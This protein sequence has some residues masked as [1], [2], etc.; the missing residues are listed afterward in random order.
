MRVLIYGVNSE[1][2]GAEL[3]LRAASERLLAAGHEPAVSSR[4][5][6][7]R[8]RREIHA[9]GVFSVES[10][11]H[12]R[13]VGLDRLPRTLTDHLSVV[14][15]GQFDYVLDASGYSLTD[16]WGMAP[17][18]TRLNRLRR[19]HAK[20]IGFSMLPQ[21]FGPFTKP[22][23]AGG[24]AKVVAYADV[25]FARDDQSASHLRSAGLDMA[26]ISV[27]PDITI[28]MS[29]APSALT[30]GRTLLVPNWNIAKR[31]DSEGESQYIASLVKTVDGLRSDG[32]D[33]VGLCHEGAKDLAVLQ[34]VDGLVSGGLEILAPRNA[35]EAKSLVA[36]AELV[37][38]GRYH[39]LVS[40]LA[41]GVPAI[42]HS[43]AHKYAALF[44]DFG[45]AEGR[46]ADPMSAEST[47][48][49]VR[50]L[51]MDKER[52]KLTSAKPAINSRLEAMW[53]SIFDVIAT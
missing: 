51:D 3:L 46:L 20:G 30:T 18:T 40:A 14:G 48:A 44:A 26:G 45:L 39:A 9:K 21:A 13:S 33:V 36:G 27:C 22:G 38:A 52:A 8:T 2:K 19:W 32:R 42:A 41:S 43:W 16:A 12:F 5:V 10:A 25:V 28:S 53:Q 7:A 47:L 37:V 1:N 34:E 11:K 29:V 15:D 17:V 4:E 50:S 31:S 49:G 35:V 6:T 24:V 23:L